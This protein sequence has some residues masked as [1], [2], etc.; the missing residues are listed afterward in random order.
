MRSPVLAVAALVGWA[1]LSPA[2]KAAAPPVMMSLD[3]IR[4]GMVGVGHTV[5]EGIKI[6]E[7]RVEVVGVLENAVGPRQSMIIARLVGGPLEKTGVIAGMSGS[8]V[9]IDG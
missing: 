4:P 7:F 1:A 8:P 2:A 6:E 5:F 9:Y 3:Q